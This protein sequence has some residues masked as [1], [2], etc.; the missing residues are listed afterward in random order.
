M[1]LDSDQQALKDFGNAAFGAEPWHGKLARIS[2]V[3]RSY[4]SQIV[5]G[6][7]PMTAAIDHQIRLGIRLEMKRLREAFAAYNEKMY[8]RFRE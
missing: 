6:D 4:I 7:K 1:P 3:S 2:G 8:G 5:R